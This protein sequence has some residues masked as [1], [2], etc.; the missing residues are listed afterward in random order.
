MKLEYRLT[1]DD[2]REL[3]A[4]VNPVPRGQKWWVQ[5]LI[6]LFLFVMLLFNVYLNGVVA[7]QLRKTGVGGTPDLPAQNLWVLLAPHLLVTTFLLIAVMSNPLRSNTLQVRSRSQQ[8]MLRIASL[9]SL[10]SGLWMIPALF[11][12]LAIYWHPTDGQLLWASFTPWSLY[13]A[14]VR[15]ILSLRRKRLTDQTWESL[16][17]LRRTNRASI[18]RAEI[19]IEDG[20]AAHQ[21]QWA[22]FKRYWETKNL[23]LL[24]NIDDV[25]ALVIPKRAVPDDRSMDELKMLISE[26]VADGK[27]LQK[28]QAFPVIVTQQAM[29]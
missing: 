24:I 8:R 4:S 16:P 29:K 15:P 9:L 28:Q 14:A 5:L 10:L 19:A 18:S 20:L 3:S 12:N 21:F 22:Y 25:P 11:P 23:L 1:R 27:F 17:S 26:N 6:W 2:F 13:F 7:A